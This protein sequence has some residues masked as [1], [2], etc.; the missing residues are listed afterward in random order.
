[1]ERFTN[2]KHVLSFAVIYKS[3]ITVK[4][5]THLVDWSMVCLLFVLSVAH[6]LKS[7][8]MIDFNAAL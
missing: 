8:T 5:L 6:R 7:K 1:M 3:L 2:S 4:V